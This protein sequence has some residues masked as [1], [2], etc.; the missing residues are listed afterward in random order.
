MF[1]A[2]IRWLIKPD[3]ASKEAFLDNLTSRSAMLTSPLR[4]LGISIPG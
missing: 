1:V 2:L 3:E 4:Y